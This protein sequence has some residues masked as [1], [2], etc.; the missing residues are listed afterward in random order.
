MLNSRCDKTAI[1]RVHGCGG[2]KERHIRYLID[3]NHSQAHLADAVVP[4]GKH[5]TVFSKPNS[6]PHYLPNL[7]SDQECILIVYGWHLRI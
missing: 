7:S 6:K 5:S 2:Y 1:E 4:I 3:Q